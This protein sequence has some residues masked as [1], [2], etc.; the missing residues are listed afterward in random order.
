MALKKSWKSMQT[1]R[2]ICLS[3]AM[4]IPNQ[5]YGVFHYLDDSLFNNPSFPM[6]NFTIELFPI[7]F[8]E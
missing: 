2:L 7:S 3:G 5:A 1:K 8:L 6:K 4:G